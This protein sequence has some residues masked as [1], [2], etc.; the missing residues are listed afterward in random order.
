MQHAHCILCNGV[1]HITK[2]YYCDSW[3]ALYGSIRTL[4]T[5]YLKQIHNKTCY[6]TSKSS[7]FAFIAEIRCFISIYQIHMQSSRFNSVIILFNLFSSPLCIALVK[8]VLFLEIRQKSK[9]ECNNVILLKI[10]NYMNN[11]AQQVSLLKVFSIRPNIFSC[12]FQ[13]QQ[14][15]FHAHILFK[16]YILKP[17]V[18]SLE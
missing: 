7:W 15:N 13:E 8:M 5:T 9:K 3:T 14:T 4:K 11:L 10:F 16:N 2:K 6:A 18:N 17:T 12:I 1:T